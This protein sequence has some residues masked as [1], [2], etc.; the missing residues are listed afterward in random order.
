VLADEPTSAL[1]VSVQAV[2]LN[3]LKDLR[4]QAD[5][6]YIVI[7]HDLDVI[8]Y[9]ADWIIVLYLGEIMEQGANTQVRHAP[10]HPYT[11]VL[12]AAVPVIPDASTPRQAAP[13]RAPGGDVPSPRHKPTGCS[14]HTRCPR[15]LGDVCVT[16]PPPVQMGDSGH[17]IRCHIPL[18]DLYALQT[19]E[20]P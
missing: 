6:S 7:S 2:I 14:F 13:R 20:T 16:Q 11:E 17:E 19:G 1:D 18:D 10:M 8:S 9:L 3:L 4:A 5:A 12:L 15:F